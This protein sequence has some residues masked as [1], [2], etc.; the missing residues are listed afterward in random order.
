MSDAPENPQSKRL[1]KIGLILG[2]FYL[3]YALVGFFAVPAVVKSQLAAV[4]KDTLHREASV[5]NVSFNPLTL[6]LGVDDFQLD[7]PDGKKFISFEHFFV[8]FQLSTLVRGALTFSEISLHAPYVRIEV[9]DSGKLNFAD[10]MEKDEEPEETPREESSELPALHVFELAISGGT[11]YFRDGAKEVPFVA[12]LTPIA[13][14]VQDFNTKRGKDSPY[15]FTASTGQG[16][17]LEWEGSFA[18]NPVRSSG[19]FSLRNI[20][21]RTLWEY[22]QERVAFEIAD[23][24]IAL[25]ARYDADTGGKV[26]VS[27]GTFT[28]ENLDVREKGGEE[29]VITV[30]QFTIGGIGLDLAKQ[31]VTLASV[32]TSGG[33]VAALNNAEGG[34]NL[35]RLFTPVTPEPPTADSTEDEAPSEESD[36]Q[37]E[38]AT[39]SAPKEEPATPVEPESDP[40][41]VRMGGFKLGEY[42]VRWNDSAVEP[43][44]DVSLAALAV[45][46]GAITIP[47]GAAFPVSIAT[48]ISESPVRVTGTA[49][50]D[51]LMLD[52]DVDVSA[53]SL[54]PT[55]G[56]VRQSAQLTIDSG[57]LDV[58]GKLGLAQN[59]QG[60]NALSYAGL[61]H[62]NEFSASAAQSAAKFA[63][64]GALHLDGI[65]LHTAPLTLALESLRI[66][67]P[68]ITIATDA[69]GKSSLAEI[70]P[71][72]PA[73]PAPAKEESAPAP[74]ISISRVDLSG[75][76]F[77]FSDES[78]SPAFVI[79]LR[80][81]KGSVTGLSS[82]P[83]KKATVDLSAS[84]NQ[85]APLTVR[86]VI[87]PLAAQAYSDLK[88][89]ARGIDLTSF[90]PYAG[91]YA[92][93]VIDKGKLDLDLKYGLEKRVLTGENKVFIDQ[94]T[95]G[96]STDSPDAT[97]LPVKLGVALLKNSAGE[98]HLDV[99]VRGELDDPSFSASGLL[100]D[101]LINIL[102]KVTTSP[103]AALGSV[104]GMAG[105]ANAEELGHIAFAPGRAALS[106]AEQ[107]KLDAVAR[108]LAAKTSLVLEI[109]GASDAQSEPPALQLARV[110]D[111]I[112][113]AYLE[114]EEIARLTAP[115]PAG[116]A[117]EIVEDF[118]EE[119]FSETWRAVR[120]RLR[121]AR[122]LAGQVLL[123][124]PEEDAAV[125]EEMKQR[126][127]GMQ[128]ITEADLRV[129]SRKRAEAIQSYLIE[130]AGVEPGRVFLREVSL[131][132]KATEES[133]SSELS[134]KV[135]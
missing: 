126:L 59:E 40:W 31:E 8:D 75:G 49:A 30:P 104:A 131:S 54:K 42:S 112:L 84:V 80:E 47:G 72:K 26:T 28:L 100:V 123:P 50:L 37:D 95:F 120:D 86:G 64:V 11:L 44:A 3:F 41:T 128:Q 135:N 48:T 110:E 1:R 46:T 36:A 7:D 111:L 13:I 97:S 96:E 83:R 63:G 58:K 87:N 32:S 2:S 122:T 69:R 134:L 68:S 66:D 99:A 101:T 102:T 103:F 9:L 94:F 6:A 38:V 5:G 82:D 130:S 115:I 129:L 43:A 114:A 127:A 23:G 113:D 133:V 60:E 92:G 108:A 124:A 119:E 12:N 93:Y 65:D 51:P 73:E 77:A 85:H 39:E 109:Q 52:L 20:R 15:A 79:A 117:R 70:F 62:V 45:E 4:A 90:S 18:I 89:D 55:E 105:I 132:A 57:T 22:V 76:E 25:G 35:Q 71:P 19:R 56:Y 118:Y 33:A 107:E 17:T 21:A 121:R 78:L 116:E 91:K 106:L 74:V 67:R 27:D 34:L 125:T 24:Q 29:P 14:S 16:E 98:I 10:L 53:L 61:V 88:I 81:L